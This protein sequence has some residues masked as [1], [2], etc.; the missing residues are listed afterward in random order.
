MITDDKKSI[1]ERVNFFCAFF[2]WSDPDVSTHFAI[3]SPVPR[4]VA[5]PGRLPDRVGVSA[6]G[7]LLRRKSAWS[8]LFKLKNSKLRKSESVRG[9]V[10]AIEYP[11]CS[12]AKHSGPPLFGLYPNGLFTF[13]LSLIGLQ[14]HLDYT[15]VDYLWRLDYRCL[16]YTQN[17]LHQI[18]RSM[19]FGLLL[20]GL[21]PK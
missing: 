3:I 12:K 16:D 18:G 2:I 1:L 7:S 15:Q 13:G 19:T 14:S 21:H 17:R 8:L 20:F 9:Y 5:T 4:G 11:V 6:L 10:G